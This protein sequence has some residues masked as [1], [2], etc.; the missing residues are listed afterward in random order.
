M[1][2]E[3]ATDNSVYNPEYIVTVFEYITF[4]KQ[5]LLAQFLHRRLLFALRAAGLMT[6]FLSDSNSFLMSCLRDT[7]VTETLLLS[8]HLPVCALPR[9][10]PPLC[11]EAARIESSPLPGLRLSARPHLPYLLIFNK[12]LF[13]FCSS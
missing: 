10:S 2:G 8:A 3:D 12:P 7:T 1:P 6:F 13:F 4:E 9:L 5:V 11:C